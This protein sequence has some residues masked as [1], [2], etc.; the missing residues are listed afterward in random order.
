M[1]QIMFETFQVPALYVTI[2]AV[3]ALWA[4][5]RTTGVV[6]DS[7]EGVTHMVPVF[8]GY[9]LPHAIARLDMGGGDLTD[10]LM[11]LLTERGYSFT[12]TAEREIVRD[13]K[14]TLGCVALDFEEELINAASSPASA[15]ERSYELP[16]GQVI[17]IGDERFRC[18][19]PLFQPSLLGKEAI[20]IHE[21]IARLITK[22]DIDIRPDLYRNVIL[23]GGNTMF[24]GLKERV[25]KELRSIAPASLRVMVAAPPERK[26]SVWIG[27]SILASLPTFRHI[28]IS[29]QDY[30]ETGPAIVHRKC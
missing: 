25:H 3:L 22:C 27:G 21:S 29:R 13:V 30:D 26:Y 15:I 2:Q 18:T 9:A 5:G 8:S 19:E 24:A 6:V 4:S 7:G 12:T 28:W 23:A 10:Y 11:K 16:D 1:A 17:T 20:G 14:E